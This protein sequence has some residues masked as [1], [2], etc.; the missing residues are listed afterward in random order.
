[1]K[2]C[3]ELS[4]AEPVY[5]TYHSQGNAGAVLTDNLSIRNWY[6]NQVMLLCCNRRFLY[7]ST[8]PDITVDESTDLE[9]PYLDKVFFKTQYLGRNIHHV[10]RSL[11]DD[12]YYVGF[13]GIDDYYVEGKSWYQEHH[14]YHDGLIFGYDGSDKTYSL[15]A[16]DK[17]WIYRPFKTTQQSFEKGRQAAFRKQKYGLIYGLKP[18][19]DKIELN[20]KLICDK[21]REYLDSSLEKYPFYTKG[22]AYGTV[23]HDYIA[24]YLNKLADGSIPY[25]RMDRRVFRLIWEHKKVMYERIQAVE[26]KL[27]FTG[28]I[29]AAYEAVVREADN[30]RLLY[31]SHHMKQRNAVLPLMRDRLLQLKKE[32]A[33]LLTRFILKTKGEIKK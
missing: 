28:E 6:L 33:Q 21:L 4:L 23:V 17:N 27:G 8:T 24:M 9:N 32:E 3:V 11:L 1:M 20:P 26:K 15:Y 2:K 25:E 16:Y 7:G 22:L 19:P 5:S 18:S 30:L 12:G 14:Y 13:T 31:A 10:I 29:S